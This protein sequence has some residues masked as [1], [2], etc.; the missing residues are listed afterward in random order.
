AWARLWND[1]LYGRLGGG[2]EHRLADRAERCQASGRRALP[3]RGTSRRAALAQTI[4]NSRRAGLAEILTNSPRAGMRDPA[5]LLPIPRAQCMQR[6]KPP[7]SPERARSSCVEL[8]LDSLANPRRPRVPSGGGRCVD[9]GNVGNWQRHGDDRHLARLAPA[10]SVP[11]PS[12]ADRVVGA[13]RHEGALVADVLPAPLPAV[14][15]SPEDPQAPRFRVLANPLIGERGDGVQL[16]GAPAAT[17]I[18][19]KRTASRRG[20]SASHPARSPAVATPA[21]A[22]ISMSRF[23]I[24]EIGVSS[25]RTTM[26]GTGRGPLRR[27]NGDTHRAPGSGRRSRRRGWSGR[28]GQ[29]FEPLRFRGGPPG[30]GSGR[31]RSFCRSA[32]WCPCTCCL[33]RVANAQV[34]PHTTVRF[35]TRPH[36]E[37]GLR[38]VTGARGTGRPLRPSRGNSPDLAPPSRAGT[39]PRRPASPTRASLRPP[40]A[41]PPALP[42]LH[43]LA[44]APALIGRPDTISRHLRTHPDASPIRTGEPHGEALEAFHRTAQGPPRKPG[45]APDRDL[46]A[47]A[48]I[49]AIESGNVV[50]ADKFGV[51][52]RTVQRWRARVS[53]DPELSD[54]VAAIARSRTELKRAQAAESIATWHAERAT[55]LVEGYST[56]R[57]LHTR[58]LTLLDAGKIDEALAA[59][60]MVDKISRSLER[61][62]SLDVTYSALNPAPSGP[63]SADREGQAAPKTEAER[64]A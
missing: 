51:T 2:G 28:R 56:L 63:P 62:G 22:S 6:T 25:P 18:S 10:A 15:P 12:R 3:E 24:S 45:P 19:S 57:A 36:P 17:S 34:K 53:R 11:R 37:C 5:D 43:R 55:T 47:D 39:P 13:H 35:F 33:M 49:V 27:A 48:V 42:V 54:R 32:S 20:A 61:A 1:P 40:G 21:S 60:N 38:I 31:G 7:R 16:T 4:T 52:A 46:M 26:T 29:P 44:S 8:R 50:A 30:S 23:S 64:S 59:S 14:G 58:V 9:A 41:L